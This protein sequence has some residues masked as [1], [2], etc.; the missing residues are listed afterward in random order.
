LAFVGDTSEKR[1]KKKIKKLL[2][3]FHSDLTKMHPR[4]VLVTFLLIYSVNAY[5]HDERYVSNQNM[6]IF[7]ILAKTPTLDDLI[8]PSIDKNER[9]TS[10]KIRKTMSV[11]INDKIFSFFRLYHATCAQNFA[12]SK[13]IFAIW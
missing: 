4:T 1:R 13:A 12:T 10:V 2:R 3:K 5:K 8:I 11:R 7:E 6:T 9:G